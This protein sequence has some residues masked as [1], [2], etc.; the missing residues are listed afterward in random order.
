MEDMRL[1]R[2]IGQQVF[3]DDP[4]QQRFVHMVIPR[5]V[6]VDTRS[7]LAHTPDSRSASLH[8]CGF[9]PGQPG[10]RQLA[11]AYGQA[12][13]GAGAAVAVVASDLRPWAACSGAHQVSRPVSFGLSLDPSLYNTRRAGSA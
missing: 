3:V 10:L 4:L 6:R 11:E 8:R 2:L 5:P 13:H 7:G 12:L 9:G 1:H